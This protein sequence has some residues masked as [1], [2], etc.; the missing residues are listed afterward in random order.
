M[1]KSS[2]KHSKGFSLV[3]VVVAVGIFSLAIVGVIGLLTPTTK[4]VSDV[5]DNDAASRVVG[6][7]QAELQSIASST[8]GWTAFTH[9]TTGL[10]RSAD[11]LQSFDD[12]LAANA[13]ETTYKSA[14]DGAP[15]ILFAS[16]DGGKIGVYSS[17][18]WGTTA[19]SIE[20]K[21]GEKFFEVSLIRN[22]DSTSSQGLS[23]PANDGAA[24]FLAYTIRLRWPAF[25][26]DGTRVGENSQ[27]SVLIV[28][29]A[30]T[31]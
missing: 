1:K 9:A 5:S 3:E 31:R 11:Q 24:G 8:N 22:W 14:Y 16:K 23:N 18:V 10:L 7:I 25:L 12:N 15:Y 19:D 30:V 4:A 29:A 28:P 17:P 13:Q 26:P 20:K 21:N 2:L 6:M 27:K